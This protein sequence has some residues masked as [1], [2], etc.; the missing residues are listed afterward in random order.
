MG[1]ELVPWVFGSPLPLLLELSLLSP[2]AS[3]LIPWSY[4]PAPSELSGVQ[5]IRSAWV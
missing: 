3:W 1:S 2:L 4:V 5:T